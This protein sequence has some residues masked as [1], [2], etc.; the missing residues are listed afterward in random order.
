VGFS[1]VVQLAP[2]AL[3]V[4]PLLQLELQLEVPWL[5]AEPWEDRWSSRRATP[6]G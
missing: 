5:L 4:R 6:A 2:A 3:V 1:R